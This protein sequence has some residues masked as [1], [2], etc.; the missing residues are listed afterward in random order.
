MVSCLLNRDGEW[1][2]D[3]RRLD[4]LGPIMNARLDLAK[5]KGCDGVEPD[6]VD[7]YAQGEQETGFDLTY[8]DQLKYNGWLAETA[9]SKDLSIGLKNDL[10]QIEDLVQQF[11][12][13]LNEQCWQYNECNLLQPFIQ[14][15][16]AV[17]NCE[18]EPMTNCPEALQS[19][20][21]SIQAPLSLN[22]QNMKMCNQNGQL[23]FF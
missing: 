19:K 8:N 2:L 9:H 14:G 6:N 12:W 3:I 20:I 13:A 7:A 4:I 23:I 1:W 15:N 11:D 22:G 16:K 21:S 17:F 10:G 18:Y 5:Q